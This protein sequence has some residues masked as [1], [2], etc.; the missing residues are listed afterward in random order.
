MSDLRAS[1]W[2]LVLGAEIKAKVITYNERGASPE[3]P[4][5]SSGITVQTEPLQVTAITETSASESEITV[6]WTDMTNSGGVAVTSYNLEWD[7]AAGN[8]SPTEA[9][10]VELVGETSDYTSLSY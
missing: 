7:N 4:E 8:G 9:Q 10:F 3:S 2:N 5:S 6:T 1:P